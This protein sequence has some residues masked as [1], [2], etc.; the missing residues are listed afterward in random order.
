MLRFT[1]VN[2]K[3]ISDI[4]MCQFIESVIQDI[5]MICNDYS[6]PSEPLTHFVH[7]DANDLCGY[8][9]IQLFPIE[10]L[11]WVNLEKN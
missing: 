5:S 1:G 11:N 6:N 8:S 7:L 9:V 2:F 3:L 4:K 10:I